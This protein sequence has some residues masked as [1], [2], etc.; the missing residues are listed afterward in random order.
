MQKFKQW[1][2]LLIGLLFFHFTSNLIWIFINNAPFPWDQATHADLSL[3]IANQLRSFQLFSILQTSNYYPILV[4]TVAS[5]PLLFFGPHLKL[6]Q[7][8]ATVFFL[9]TISIIYLYFDLI[10]QN[11]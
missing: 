9:G 11:K 8:V 7:I 5:I 3:Q 4:H 6:T 10:A 2:L 1:N